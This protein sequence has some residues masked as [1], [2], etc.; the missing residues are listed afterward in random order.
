MVMQTIEAVYDGKVLRPKQ[1]LEI[2]AN[3]T[4]MITIKPINAKRISKKSAL[5]IIEA[6]NVDAPSDWAE[7]I[8]KYLAA[9]PLTY[10]NPEA[11]RSGG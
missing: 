9:A 2:K 11:I 7:N 3:T 1:R 5:E 10:S 8:K 4:V 6:L